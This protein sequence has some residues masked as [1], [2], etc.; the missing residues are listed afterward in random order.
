MNKTLRFLSLLLLGTMLIAA[1]KKDQISPGDNNC[2]TI[3]LNQDIPTI[4]KLGL[5]P[6]YKGEFNQWTTDNIVQSIDLSHQ[7]G[8]QVVHYGFRWNEIQPTTDQFEWVYPDSVMNAIT[9]NG[10]KASIIL[11]TINTSDIDDIPEDMRF[12]GFTEPTFASMYQ[13]LVL[14]FLDRYN[15]KIDYLWLGNE[16]DVYFHENPTEIPDYVQF[17]NNS[18]TIIK[19][20]YPEL[21]V[22]MI[23][24]YHDALNNGTTDIYHEFSKADILGFS[25]YEQFL[26]NSPN[27]YQQRVEELLALTE[28]IGP[29]IAITETTWSSSGF[30]G[31]V[32]KQ[33]IFI[34]QALSALKANHSKLEFFTF[35]GTY[36]F[37]RSYVELSGFSDTE[38]VN[39]LSTLSFIAETGEPKSSYCTFV[40]RLKSF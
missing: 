5:A 23:F 38:I 39:W 17:F 2:T 18:R 22:G 7:L 40:E 10:Q 30:K 15:G 14:E 28:N 24:T 21:D 16:V 4:P 35:Y 32:E 25:L 31:S 6:T 1:C 29:K 13:Q 11:H 27:K 20:A 19:N 34:E 26:S 9:N 8:T 12:Q 33:E 37:A 3:N 36:D